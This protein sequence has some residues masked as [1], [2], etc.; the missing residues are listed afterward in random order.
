M[1]G[2]YKFTNKINR[3]VYIGQTSNI[4]RRFYEHLRRTDQQIDQAIQKYGVN[5]FLFEILE[6][7]EIEKLNERKFLD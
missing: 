7:C 5:N 6:E 4:T 3:K 1:I 2:I